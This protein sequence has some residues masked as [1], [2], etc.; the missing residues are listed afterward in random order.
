MKMIRWALPVLIG[1]FGCEISRA[2]GIVRNITSLA[3]QGPGSFRDL[4]A[5]ANQGD[6][7]RFQ[8]SGLVALASEIRLDTHVVVEGF[9]PGR[10]V[11]SG[12]GTHRIFRIGENDTVVFHGLTLTRGFVD[13]AQEE[14]G[15]AVR[16][17]GVFTAY[18]CVFS[19]NQAIYGGAIENVCFDGRRSRLELYQCAFLRNKTNFISEI[20]NSSGG[21][22]YA[23]ARQAGN[24]VIV[25]ENCTFYENTA[26]T[27][28]GAFFLIDKSQGLSTMTLRYCTVVNNHAG[29]RCGGIDI[30]EADSVN[31]IGTLVFGNTGDYIRP[32]VYGQVVSFGHNLIGDTS[33]TRMLPTATDLIGVA[34]MLG[35]LEEPTGYSPTL[36]LTC[37]S[38]AINTG[39][40]NNFPAIDG[41]GQVRSGAPD[42]GA[43]ERLSSDK[44]VTTLSASG[45]GSL[46]QAILNTCPGDTLDLS[47]LEGIIPFEEPIILDHSITVQGN[48]ES[49][50]ILTGLAVSRLFEVQAGVQAKFDWLT[51]SDAAPGYFGGGAFL[52]KGRLTIENSTFVN[53]Q[54]LSGGAVAVYGDGDTATFAATNVTFSQNRATGLSGGALDIRSYSSPAFVHLNHCTFAQNSAFINGG[55]LAQVG[56]GAVR[57]SNSIIANNL[58]PLGTNASGSFI[59]LGSTL[60]RDTTGGQWTNA[61]GDKPGIDPLLDTYGSYGG[62]TG[63]YRL[64]S[65][66]PA[67]DAGFTTASLAIDQRG[68]PRIFN[69]NPDVG[70][71]EYDPQTR[72][73]PA[74]EIKNWLIY[75]NPTLGNL[76]V[77]V[78]SNTAVFRIFDLNG[79]QILRGELTEERNILDVSAFPSGI[80]LLQL[81]ENG[82]VSTVRFCKI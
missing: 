4:A 23:D 42:I 54:A 62:P 20:Y 78:I 81:Q 31:M 64:L 72:L 76:I 82:A 29:K 45:F 69:G 24:S 12:G 34:P 44:E 68:F 8:V 37:F 30:A 39:D 32:E 33:S 40:P 38:P 22:I 61:T 35:S 2:Q 6:T 13:L 41:R 18:N 67:I 9:G 79:R 55:A 10:T 57:L 16:N 48:P 71:Y 14:G 58:A 63:T 1:L 11:I 56:S 46:R 60:V 26:A 66:S 21:A 43:H 52:N 36:P 77:S 51:F 25:A 17:R 3:D 73:E 27:S 80:Y 59:S 75:P 53:N 5:T 15:G 28:G 49:P 70:A 50:L 19:D 7:L 65:G 74:S 47:N